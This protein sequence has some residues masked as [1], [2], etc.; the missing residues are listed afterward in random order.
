MVHNTSLNTQYSTE[1]FPLILHTKIM[2]QLMSIGEQGLPAEEQ[3]SLAN[4]KVNAQQPCSLNF[5]NGLW[6]ETGTQGHSRSFILQSV[7]G[8]QEVAYHHV[9]LLVL[10]L[11]FPKK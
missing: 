8:R 3:E 4:T 1:Q 5:E 2:A 6:H 10:S 9:I 7:S 11:M